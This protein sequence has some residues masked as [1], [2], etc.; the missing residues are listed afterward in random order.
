MT[1]TRRR[2]A[3]VTVPRSDSDRDCDLDWQQQN[4]S[5]DHHRIIVMMAAFNLKA[6]MTVSMRLGARAAGSLPVHGTVTVGSG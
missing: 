3:A 2:T 1:Q 6:T 5:N 4:S